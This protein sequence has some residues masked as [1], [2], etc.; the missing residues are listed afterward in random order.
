MGFFVFV[1]AAACLCE[2]FTF[3]LQKFEVSVGN[4]ETATKRN[5]S[6]L[7]GG[8]KSYLAASGIIII[9]VVVI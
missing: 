2:I 9:V 3:V 6:V 1:A 7:G 5:L 8:K 4:T